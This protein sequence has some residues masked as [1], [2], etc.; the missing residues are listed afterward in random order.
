MRQQYLKNVVTL[1]YDS[2][3]C[4]GCGMCADVC[5]HRVFALENGKA[6]I[7]ERD[8]CIECGGC[9][10]N[11]PTNAITVDANVGCAYAI[12]MGWLTGTEPS[13]DGSSGECC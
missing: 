1:E 12:I 2:G 3:K 11:C 10:N 9:Q 13:C 4:I 7:S 8:R 5:P 6:Q